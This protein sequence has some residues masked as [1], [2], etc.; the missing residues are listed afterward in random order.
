MTGVIEGY[1]LIYMFV[2]KP[3]LRGKTYVKLSLNL[4]LRQKK[5]CVYVRARRGQP[6]KF[7]V[8]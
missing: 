1:T 5:K 7:D 4:V 3:K 6:M 8:C 2:V